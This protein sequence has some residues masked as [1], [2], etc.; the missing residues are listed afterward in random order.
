M[1]NKEILGESRLRKLDKSYKTMIIYSGKDFF[2]KGTS[3]FKIMIQGKAVSKEMDE[4]L[5]SIDIGKAVF[6]K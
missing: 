4:Y 3:I 2:K 5:N 1:Q 6:K